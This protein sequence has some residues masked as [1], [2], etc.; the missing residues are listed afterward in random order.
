MFI[1]KLF[2]TN[3]IDGCLDGE[4]TYSLPSFIGRG[5]IKS[6]YVN[7]MVVKIKA[8]LADITFFH[9]NCLL[10]PSWSEG[11][12]TRVHLLCWYSHWWDF[13]SQCFLVILY[14]IN[15]FQGWET[16]AAAGQSETCE[17]RYGVMITAQCS[18]SSHWLTAWLCRTNGFV[19]SE[20]TVCEILAWCIDLP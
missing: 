1:L 16:G 7:F 19:S 17:T 12:Y 8:T 11:R 20:C 13:S 15:N 10:A 9:L 5:L 18:K 14:V 3:V 4:Q 6:M 2:F